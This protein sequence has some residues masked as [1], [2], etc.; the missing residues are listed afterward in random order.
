VNSFISLTNLVYLATLTRRVPV[1]PPFVP[2]HVGHEHQSLPFGDIFDLPALSA[3]LGMPV[4][5]WHHVKRMH[6]APVE[7]DALGCWSDRM[8]RDGKTDYPWQSDWRLGIGA[9]SCMLC[10]CMC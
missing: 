3:T 10:L 6:P 7:W 4:L 1:L 9:R 2:M 8:T 5:D